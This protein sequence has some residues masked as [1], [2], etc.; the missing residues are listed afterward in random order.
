[1]IVQ[2]VMFYAHTL[3][4]NCVT[5]N[6][7]LLVRSSV[8][9]IQI[10]CF[11]HGQCQ[12]SEQKPT[13]KNFFG[14]HNYSPLLTMMHEDCVWKQTVEMTGWLSSLMKCLYPQGSLLLRSKWCTN[15]ILTIFFISLATFLNFI[16]ST[17]NKTT[18]LKR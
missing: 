1:M 2:N 8:R 15:K 12:K 10:L 18:V 17:C 7:F 16:C 5:L 6:T 9:S 11:L 4:M 13:T 14:F 3:C